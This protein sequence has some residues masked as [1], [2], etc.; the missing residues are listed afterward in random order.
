MLKTIL[1]A[2]YKIKYH[3]LNLNTI[4]LMVRI[5]LYNEREINKLH[6][7]QLFFYHYQEFTICFLRINFNTFHYRYS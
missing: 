6:Y 1:V 5:D 2:K 4:I 3:Q 7:V